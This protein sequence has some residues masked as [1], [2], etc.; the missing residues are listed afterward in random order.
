[1]K[2]FAH[3][4]SAYRELLAR[5]QTFFAG[6]WRHL[7]IRC[8]WHS[9]V[10]GPTASGKTALASILSEDTGAGL[11]RVNVSNWMPAGANNRAV[12][13][14][15]ET[16][17]SHINAHNRSILFF[18]ELDKIYHET[19]WMGYIRGELFEWLDGRLPLGT[20]PPAFGEDDYEAQ[21][22][23]EKSL[24]EKLRSTVFIV[25]AGTFQQFYETRRS[26]SIGFNPTEPESGIGPTAD[27]I[28]QKLPREL[29]TRFNSQLLFL[30][31]LSPIH[32]QTL[33]REAEKSLPDWIA[34]AFRRAAIL[35]MEQ[36]I[37]VKSGCRFI[38]EA[39]ADALQISQP[40]PKP[41]EDPFAFLEGAD[42]PE[43]ECGL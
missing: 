38:E 9:L 8:R 37:A 42:N 22:P 40:P 29:T 26:P 27:Y 16:V 10:I 35:R 31:E 13:E 20:K 23:T 21:F 43:L 12:A 39:L 7:P 11:L 41:E 32:Y 28:A 5:A 3:Q 25:G 2:I 4:A 15:L 34:P 17:V 18:D 1:M 24:S 33:I 30:P 6:H 14:T 36:A 19:P